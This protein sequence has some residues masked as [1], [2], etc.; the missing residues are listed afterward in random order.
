MGH[1][2]LCIKHCEFILTPKTPETGGL[3][4]WETPETG[5]LGLTHLDPS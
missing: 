3:G 5:R 1:K 2:L 4:D